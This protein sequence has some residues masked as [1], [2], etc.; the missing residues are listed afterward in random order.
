MACRALLHRLAPL[1]PTE[2]GTG[3]RGRIVLRHPGRLESGS[4][5]GF[6]TGGPSRPLQRYPS[7]ASYTSPQTSDERGSYCVGAPR[8]SQHSGRYTRP[9]PIESRSFFPGSRHT[10][11]TAASPASGPSLPRLLAFLSHKPKLHLSSAVTSPNLLHS[12]IGYE[13][14]DETSYFRRPYP[15]VF[16]RQS[17]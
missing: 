10:F 9:G 17:P 5:R 14:P 11:P 16:V 12:V 15:P 3:H 2:K 13:R 4:T 1:R 6:V 7:I 8:A